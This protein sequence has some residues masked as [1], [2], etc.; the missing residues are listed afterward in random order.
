MTDWNNIYS[1]KELGRSLEQT[2]GALVV[3][4][5]LG[6]VAGGIVGMAGSYAVPTTVRH[7]AKKIKEFVNDPLEIFG[8]Y[9]TLENFRNACFSVPAHLAYGSALGLCTYLNAD[10]ILDGRWEL[11]AF[12]IG[13]N[14]VSFGYEMYRLGVSDAKESVQS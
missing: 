14:L 3:R 12:P 1:I 8:T 10:S 2:V 7:A 13:T 9:I 5:P 4:S 6:L 11:A